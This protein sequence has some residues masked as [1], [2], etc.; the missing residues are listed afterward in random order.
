MVEEGAVQCCAG[1]TVWALKGRANDITANPLSDTELQ[2]DAQT[3]TA[4][5]TQIQAKD[6]NTTQ[7]QA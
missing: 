1:S 4:P 7:I 5:V 2:T 6:T 3:D